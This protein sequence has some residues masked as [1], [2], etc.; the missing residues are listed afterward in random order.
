[1]NSVWAKAAS[2]LKLGD[3]DEKGLSDLFDEI[4]TDKNGLV[5]EP[6]L[7]EAITSRGTKISHSWLHAVLMS[8][9]TLPH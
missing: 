1:M 4:D 7:Y 3:L 2:A 9:Y 5:G 6:E 8:E